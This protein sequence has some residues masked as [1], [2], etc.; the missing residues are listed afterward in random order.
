MPKAYNCLL[1]VVIYFSI[2]LFIVH[3]KNI[4]EI[5]VYLQTMNFDSFHWSS[6]SFSQPEYPKK[7]RISDA[8]K[9]QCLTNPLMTQNLPPQNIPL[10]TSILSGSK[11]W[12]FM[13]KVQVILLYRT[14]LIYWKITVNFW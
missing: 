13:Y 11:L 6:C 8:F 9:V 3:G 1:F 5:I 7:K 14:T 2:G 12:Y 4:F 10:A